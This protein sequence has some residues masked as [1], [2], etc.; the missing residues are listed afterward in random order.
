MP[1]AVHLQ[2][3]CERL[4][5]RHDWVG[6]MVGPPLPKQPT[7]AQASAAPRI[8]RPA[9]ATKED[10][11]VILVRVPLLQLYAQLLDVRRVSPFREV[12]ICQDIIGREIHRCIAIKRHIPRDLFVCN[13]GTFAP[14]VRIALTTGLLV[15]RHLHLPRTNAALREMT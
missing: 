5:A 7:P 13:A 4:K 1:R 2:L 12:G 14:I 6:R 3:I 10:L 11:A 8:A 15:R 9:I